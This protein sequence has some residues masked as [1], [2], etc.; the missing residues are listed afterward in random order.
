[1]DNLPV[2]K[3]RPSKYSKTLCRDVLTLLSEGMGIK[4]AT[5]KCG[6]TYPSWRTW[7]DKDEKLREAYYKS[8]EAGIEMLISGVD[9]KLEDALQL[10]DIPMSRVKLL[11]IYSKSIMWQASKL[12]PKQYGTEKQNK[13]SIIDADDKKIEISWASD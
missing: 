8:K 6:I 3:G 4:H 1:M 2:K 13:L 5:A 11:E 10:K 12:A 7:M 9:E